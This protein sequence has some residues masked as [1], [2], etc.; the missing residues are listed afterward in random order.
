[1]TK[2]R[3]YRLE[4]YANVNHLRVIRL[5]LT[6]V[7]SADA[8]PD[9]KNLEGWLEVEMTA[10]A[11][12]SPTNY[13]WTQLAGPT[14]QLIPFGTNNVKCKYTTPALL[15]S[16][17]LVFSVKASYADGSSSGEGTTTHGVV[18][19]TL[20]Q[21]NANGTFTPVRVVPASTVIPT[22]AGFGAAPFGTSSFGG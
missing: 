19:S 2:V 13:V 17:S 3:V 1:M 5:E 4:T 16:A 14:V 8:G 21:V 20:R 6:G 11:P 22:A 18:R 15:G 9:V 10:S 7:G 12:G